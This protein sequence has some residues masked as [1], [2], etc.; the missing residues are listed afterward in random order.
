[1]PAGL[2]AAVEAEDPRSAVVAQT[3]FWW[4]GGALLVE[5][6]GIGVRVIRCVPWQRRLAAEP[7]Q[8][9]EQRYE[10]PLL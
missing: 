6:G 3:S 7:S 4:R 8:F 1:M 2:E 5:C 9:V 10:Y